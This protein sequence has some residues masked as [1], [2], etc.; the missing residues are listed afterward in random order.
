MHMHACVTTG[1]HQHSQTCMYAPNAHT[2][3]LLLGVQD[4]YL[5]S[6][7]SLRWRRALSPRKSSLQEEWVLR[8][9]TLHQL[10]DIITDIYASKSKAD[11]RSATR[12]FVYVQAILLLSIA[13]MTVT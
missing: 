9:L 5:M 8:G 6:Q 4:S 3:N 2:Q 13:V 1:L 12:P 10:K 11:V 7:K